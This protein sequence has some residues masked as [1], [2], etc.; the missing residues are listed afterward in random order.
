MKNLPAIVILPFLLSACAHE[1]LL[2]A[3]DPSTAS[4]RPEASA[5]VASAHQPAGIPAPRETDAHAGENGEAATLPAMELSEDIL[6]RY[7]TAEIAAQRGQWEGAYM[8]MLSLAQQTRDP[9]IARR[10]TEVAL[11]AKRSVEALAAARLWRELAPNSEEAAQYFLGF[12]ILGNRLGEAR[13][14]E[15]EKRRPAPPPRRGPIMLQ[16]QRLLARAADKDAAFALLEEVFAPYRSVPESR[17]AL[18][19]AA[20]LK[21]DGERAVQEARAGLAARPDSELAALTLAQVIEDKEEAGA[22]LAAFLKQHPKAREVRL[23]YARM[24]IEQQEFD[25]ARGQFK[26]L[27]ADDPQDLTV[28]YALGLLGTRSNN[29]EEAETYLTTYLKVLASQPDEGRDPTQAILILAQIAEQRQD[30]PGALKWLEQ[31]EPATPQAYLSAQIRRAQLVAKGGDIPAARKLLQGVDLD[32]EEEK[33]QLVLA[34]AQILRTANRL[35]EAAKVLRAALK[36]YPEQTDL[37]YDYAMLAEKMN[38]L[39]LMETSLRKIIAMAP[40]N[41]HAYNALGYSLAD[42][43]L[44]LDEAFELI[45]KA[46]EL[47]PEDPFILDSLGWVHF[48]RGNLKEAET[49][50]RRAYQMRPDPE[51]AA[52]LGEVLW[53]TGQREDAKKLWRDANTKDPKNDTLKSTLAR[54][55]VSL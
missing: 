24:L 43:N 49:L 51:I 17:L 40:E 6:F 23:A 15:E 18:A 10:A 52:H 5:M 12:S 54:L 3:T 11:G 48:R 14:L 42:R 4:G 50:L 19:Q 16:A 38:K 29:L 39:D 45:R 35:P 37:L 53:S 44:R 27:L 1:T 28:L 55:Q 31:I 36:R 46:H 33:V 8:T 34:E 20:A 47:A 25:A 2:S 26:E 7:L 9:R 22:A 30:I 21:G 32:S 41:Q 13:P